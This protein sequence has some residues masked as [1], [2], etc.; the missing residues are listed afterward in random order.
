MSA[1]PCSTRSSSSRVIAAASQVSPQARV[2]LRPGAT[3]GVAA[4]PLPTAS[5]AR[6]RDLNGTPR[7]AK[8][9]SVVSVVSV[10]WVMT[11]HIL[12]SLA[13]KAVHG[14]TGSRVGGRAWTS[15]QGAAEVRVL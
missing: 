10:V 15:D 8:V 6:T 11:S 3:A 14:R 5:S 7:S 13:L 1:A 2:F 9:C 4:T 12:N